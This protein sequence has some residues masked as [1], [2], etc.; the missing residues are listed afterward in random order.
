MEHRETIKDR[1]LG[2]KHWGTT[3]SLQAGR[4][5]GGGGDPERKTCWQPLMAGAKTLVERC[6]GLSDCRE[7]AGKP[8]PEPSFLPNPCLLLSHLAS[9]P[10]RKAQDKGA[11]RCSLLG[12]QNR[13]EKG[14]RE[15]GRT[16][17]I[18]QLCRT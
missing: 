4:G 3:T 10:N 6:S 11:H 14:Q 16:S 9:Q 8:V 2:Y 17:S 13:V 1:T 12:A 7:K 15:S 18:Q 5:E